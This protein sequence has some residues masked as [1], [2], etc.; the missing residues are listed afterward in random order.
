MQGFLCPELCGQ[1]WW[2]ARHLEVVF[3]KQQK[4]KQGRKPSGHSGF[5]LCL[6]YYRSEGPL[7]NFQVYAD[8]LHDTGELQ[9]ICRCFREMFNQPCWQQKAKI[10][11]L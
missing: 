10:F 2:V 4:E 5:G 1:S 3:E 8:H 6:V 9:G 11:L 7:Q